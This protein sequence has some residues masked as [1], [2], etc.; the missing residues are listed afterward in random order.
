MK[1]AFARISGPEGREGIL[2]G[3]CKGTQP[4]K[5]QEGKPSLPGEREQTQALTPNPEEHV[6]AWPPGTGTI[7]W[8]S[9][10]AV[11]AD[12]LTLQGRPVNPW[13]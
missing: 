12:V 13:G 4:P 5:L 11:L 6:R 1:S 2:F 9:P 3:E 8:P 10:V 7:G